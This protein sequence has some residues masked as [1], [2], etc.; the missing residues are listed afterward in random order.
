METSESSDSAHSDCAAPTVALQT[1]GCKLNQAETEFLARRFARG[2]FN[3]VS[4]TDNPDVYVLNTCTVTHVADRKCRQYLRAFHRGNPNALVVATGCYTQ[5]DE[6]AVRVD[7]VDITVDNAG[8]E[9]LVETVRR[10]LGLGEM[11]GNRERE[12][13]PRERQRFRAMVKVQDGCS[14]GCGYCIVPYVRGGEWSVPVDEV[15]DEIKARE[16]EGCGEVVL[17]GTRIGAYHYEG[18]DG[19]LSRILEETSIP[20]IRLSSLQPGELSGHLID[21]WQSS[22]R[23]CRHLHMSL[24]SGSDPVLTRMRRRYSIA[25]YE[26]AMNAVRGKM[27][28][29][30]IT[31]D[32]IA[33]FPGE[34]EEEF[35]E[36]YRF[37]EKAGFAGMHIF[38]YSKRGGTP[39]DRMPKQVPDRV[40]RAR[41]R[42][43]LE[44]AEES[45][46][47]FRRS[48]ES[49]KMTVLW[50][51]RKDGDL[52]VGHT[53]NYIKVYTRSSETLVGR[54][55]MTELGSEYEQ[56]LWGEICPR[57]VSAGALAK[58]W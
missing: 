49:G 54:L 32:V 1:V 21:L 10:E 36:S 45:A 33:G 2:G 31:T 12:V 55:S 3:I 40:K 39:A 20:R 24:Q 30:A 23:L 43:L 26:A 35:E 27:P 44:L 28:D 17:T 47:S 46:V 29:M 18:I 42:R 50:E 8:K 41:S 5:R 16:S 57:S 9:R 11:N 7:G 58:G 13:V 14:H 15:L 48:F 25:E 22:D 53:G 51:E 19:L 4:P 56:G 38:P 6:G 37:C 34:T 52:W